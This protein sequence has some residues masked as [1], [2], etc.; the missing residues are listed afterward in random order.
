MSYETV[1]PIWRA[2]RDR[3]QKSVEAIPEENINVRLGKLTVGDLLYH[4]A[5]V[6][7]MFTDWFFDK[8]LSDELIRPKDLQG[9][10]QLL[11]NSND[12]FTQAM[13][14]LPNSAWNQI[15]ESSFGPS[16]PLEAV[17]RLMNHAGIHCGQILYIQK[18]G[19]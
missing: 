17:G 7:Y 11:K 10:I 15:V 8:P 12:H 6:E 19:E 16:T 2:L 9:Y 13:K 14:E 3:F 4:T 1:L 5:E 18:Y